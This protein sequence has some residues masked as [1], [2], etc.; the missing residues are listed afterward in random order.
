MIELVRDVLP[1]F[2]PEYV[3]SICGVPVEI[4]EELAHAY[5][6]AKAPFIRL[7]SGVSRYG[8]GAMSCRCINALPAVVGAWQHLGGG[9][10]SSSS[11]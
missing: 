9:L 6:K 7:G 8:N 11:R 10:L 3:S 4:I 1:T 2:T 5:A